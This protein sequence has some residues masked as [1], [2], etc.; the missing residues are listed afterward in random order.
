MISI[1]Q[2]VILESFEETALR[3]GCDPHLLFP[4][5]IIQPDEILRLRGLKLAFDLAR[6]EAP[7]ETP[8]VVSRHI[9]PDRRVMALPSEDEILAYVQSSAYISANICRTKEQLI[10][11]IE[12]F[13]KEGL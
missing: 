12:R 3:G 4:V 5:P 9:S 2:C 8:A 11:E 1:S 13:R 6:Y 10:Q 7:Q